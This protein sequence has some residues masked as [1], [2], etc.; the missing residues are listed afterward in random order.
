MN[1]EFQ[2]FDETSTVHM[3]QSTWIALLCV[4]ILCLCSV[5]RLKSLAP[6]A[7][8]ANFIYFAALTIVLCY[9]FTEPKPFASLPAFPRN[10]NKLPLFFGTV[11]FAFEGV[12]VVSRLYLHSFYIINKLDSQVLVTHLKPPLSPIKTL[13]VDCCENVFKFVCRY[14]Q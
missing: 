3:Q 7:L 8:C 4:P 12:A 6:I 10:W 13:T 11:I 2:F 5:R 14:C 1:P 9:L